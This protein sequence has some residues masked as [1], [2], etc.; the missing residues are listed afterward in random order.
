[1][2]S[3]IL[4]TKLARAGGNGPLSSQMH[5]SRIEKRGFTPLRGQ[6]PIPITP[7]ASAVPPRAPPVSVN[8]ATVTYGFQWDCMLYRVETQAKW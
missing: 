5:V 4:C 6:L 1:M 7:Y 2:V 8:Y 3:I